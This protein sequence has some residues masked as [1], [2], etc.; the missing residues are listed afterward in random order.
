M[1]RGDPNSEYDTWSEPDVG[2]SRTRMGLSRHVLDLIEK[3]GHVMRRDADDDDDSSD[4]EKGRREK[5]EFSIFGF[6]LRFVA[7]FHKKSN[8][9]ASISGGFPEENVQSDL[10]AFYI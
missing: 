4:A 3:T 8:F 9:F 7:N 10:F 1:L 6:G 5:R 2:A